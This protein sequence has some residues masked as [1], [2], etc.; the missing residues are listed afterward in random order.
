MTDVPVTGVPVRETV[1]L[2]KS[3]FVAGAQ[4]L[5]RLYWQVYEPEFAA[6]ADAGT[7]ARMDQGT[8]VG[9]EA[10]KA[11]PGG[12]LV[13]ADHQHTD[14][15]LAQTAELI[16]DR[17]VPAIFEAALEHNGVLVRVDIL[18]RLPR[19]RWRLVE[20]KSTTE[21]R[22]HHLYDVAIQ[23]YIAA[24]CGLRVSAAGLMHLNREYRY[25]GVQYNPHR[26]F[27]IED[28]TPQARSMEGDV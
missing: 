3:R 12:V 21:V 4:C 18:E 14:D 17:S 24:G 9:V 16:A 1:R 2:S 23:H 22:E 11:F 15:A 5:K 10:R 13:T 27:V 28:L 20:V 7:Q 6:L 19:D 25:S 8:A 26:L